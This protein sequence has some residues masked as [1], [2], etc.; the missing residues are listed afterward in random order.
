MSFGTIDHKRPFRANDHQR[1]LC[2]SARSLEP[3]VGEVWALG[4]V[5]PFAPDAPA[6][7]GQTAARILC[8]AGFP[9]LVPAIAAS[10]APLPTLGVAPH[11]ACAPTGGAAHDLAPAGG[12]ALA[13][14]EAPSPAP[15]VGPPTTVDPAPVF[16]GAPLPVPSLSAGAPIPDSSEVSSRSH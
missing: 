1:W 8:A 15:S 10:R 14:P 3:T 6:P 2:T 13:P 4:T 5:D 7:G 12:H 16:V 9:A 11:L